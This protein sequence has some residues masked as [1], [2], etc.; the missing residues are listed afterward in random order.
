M[1][2]WVSKDKGVGMC[3]A[4]VGPWSVHLPTC[5]CRKRGE[6]LQTSKISSETQGL[7]RSLD[8]DVIP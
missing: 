2:G 5:R 8:F 1:G 6:K 4:H 7:E 3:R